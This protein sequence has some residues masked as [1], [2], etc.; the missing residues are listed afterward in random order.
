[1]ICRQDAIVKLFWR[2]SVSLVKF[3]YWSKFH[4]S[5]ITGSEIMIIFVY[6]EFDQKSGNRK[7]PRLNFAQ[8]LETE[9]S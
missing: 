9:T 8:Y 2:C 1:M 6:K 4:V 5:I 7:Y 3:S